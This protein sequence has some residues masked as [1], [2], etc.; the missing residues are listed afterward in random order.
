MMEDQP[1][2][3]T[4]AVALQAKVDQL[5]RQIG[6][7]KGLIAEFEN[8]RKRL[9][10]DA[11]RQRKYSAEPL[12]RDLLTV[13]DNLDWAARAAE[14]VGDAGPLAKGVNAT[15]TLFLDVLKRHGIARIEI[16]PGM[17]FDPN[18]HQAVSQVPTNDHPPGSV[19]QV[20][21]NGFVLHD[22]I[23]RPASVIVAGEAPAGGSSE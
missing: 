12:A 5:E 7:Y 18:R 17:A 6:D 4:E 20:M 1:A 22:R 15:I 2:P 16:E 8:A 19:V 9:A 3:T 21:Q 23:V 11:D 14:K 13:M 10:A